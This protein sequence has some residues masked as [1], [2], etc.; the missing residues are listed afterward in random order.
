M[1]N[2]EDDLREVYARYK[3]EF[4]AAALRKYT[5]IEVG[6]PLEKVIA[7]L[8]AVHRTETM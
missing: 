5:E 1:D 8:E 7:E 2:D 6:I 4:S 3:K